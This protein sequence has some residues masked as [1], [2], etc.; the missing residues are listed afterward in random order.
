MEREDLI[1][2][3]APDGIT[4]PKALWEHEDIES[5]KRV[6]RNSLVDLLDRL[7]PSF[8]PAPKN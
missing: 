7:G 1:P 3:P 2:T 4:N 8:F 6:E 5:L